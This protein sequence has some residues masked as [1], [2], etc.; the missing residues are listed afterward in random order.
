[1]K[2]GEVDDL[3]IYH[4]PFTNKHLG[5][6]RVMFTSVKSAKE[7]VERLNK[8]SVM[9]KIIKVFLDAFGKNFYNYFKMLFSGVILFRIPT[10]RLV[11]L[12]K[13]FRN[14]WNCIKIPSNKK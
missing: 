10:M 1:M 3:F 2:Y 12:R 6:A 9:G 8:T 11:Q 7:C 13:S 14:E 4:H 5:L